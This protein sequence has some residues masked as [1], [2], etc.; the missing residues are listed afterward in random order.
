M[1]HDINELIDQLFTNPVFGQNTARQ[2]ELVN[3]QMIETNRAMIE[4]NQ[5]AIARNNRQIQEN[6]AYLASL[7]NTFN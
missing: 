4:R 1:S 2:L 3:D 7:N 6:A 5:V